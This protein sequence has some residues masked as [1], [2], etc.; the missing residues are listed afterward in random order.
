[1]AK[2][3]VTLTLDSATLAAMRKL[4]GNR[5]LSSEVQRA[6]AERVA[7]LKHLAALDDWLKELDAAHGP[8]PTETLDWAAKQVEDW[9]G[10]AKRRKAG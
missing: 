6:V 7:K 10:Q 2:E 5:S 4:V 3:K 1:M 8:I 9:A